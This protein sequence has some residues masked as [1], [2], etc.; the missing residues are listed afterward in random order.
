[1]FCVIEYK[2]QHYSH[3]LIPEFIILFVLYHGHILALNIL[4]SND[5]LNGSVTFLDLDEQNHIIK[6]QP[7][8]FVNVTLF[9]AN[10]F[11]KLIASI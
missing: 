2:W 3:T 5:L 10:P 6:R 11:K 7:L 8:L 1:M 4:Q 9:L